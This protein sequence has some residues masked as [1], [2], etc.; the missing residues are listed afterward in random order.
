MVAFTLMMT[1]FSLRTW[2]RNGVACDELI[3]LP[4]TQH[5]HEIGVEGPLLEA[6]T[7]EVPSLIDNC[8][9]LRSD[10]NVDV[11]SIS[12]ST[13]QE[14]KP[15]LNQMGE[16][17]A[18][19]GLGEDKS[20]HSHSEENLEMISLAANNDIESEEIRRIENT[21]TNTGSLFLRWTQKHPGLVKLWTFFFF[22]PGTTTNV[23]AYAPSGP[24]V[25]GASLDLSMPIL[26][27]FHIF[28]EAFNHI[29]GPNDS[30][31]VKFLPISFLTV[32]IVRTFLPFSPRFR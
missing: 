29:Q 24:S 5:G 16:A 15:T 22:R 6:V 9:I 26:F 27:N 13:R 2:R 20:F 25:F 18:D 28:I 30:S 8:D 23:D 7:P 17:E 19:S 12:T 32:L 21:N 14:L 11:N 31:V 4:G 10:D 1:A 3:F